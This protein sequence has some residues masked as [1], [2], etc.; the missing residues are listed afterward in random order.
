M[1]A[2]VLHA[3]RDDTCRILRSVARSLLAVP[4]EHRSHAQVVI[5]VTLLAGYTLFLHERLAF[6]VRALHALHHVACR[7]LHFLLSH[8]MHC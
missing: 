5:F 8:S 1:H 7:L 4:I 6:D 3:S 2:L